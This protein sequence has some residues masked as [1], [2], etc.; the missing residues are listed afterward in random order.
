M[1]VHIPWPVHTETLYSSGVVFFVKAKSWSNMLALMG[2]KDTI[3]DAVNVCAYI[4]KLIMMAVGSH[5][6]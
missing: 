3:N 6:A 2:F 4:F 5:F 1:A